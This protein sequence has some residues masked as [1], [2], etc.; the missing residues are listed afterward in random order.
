[1]GIIVALDIGVASVGWA[2]LDMDKE[3]ILE[4]GSNIFP[5]A[6]A[7]NNQKR[8]SMRQARRIKRRERIRIS[9][10]NK[11]WEKCIFRVPNKW[12]NNLVELRVHALY[13]EVSISELYMILQNALKHRGI[14]YLD[15]AL[16]DDANQGSGYEAMIRMNQKAMETKF[17]CE[18]QMERL[19]KYGQY[20]GDWKIIDSE[21]GE[22]IDFGN[23]FTTSAYKKEL[24]KIFETQ[25]KYHPELTDEFIDKYLKIFERKRK[26]YEGPGN[27]KSRTDYGKY[28]TRKNENGEYITEDNIF[29][30]LIGKCSVYPEELRAAGASYTSQEFNVLN[31]LNNL[32]INGRKLECEEKH[33]IVETIKTSK[34]VTMRKIIENVMGEKIEQLSGARIDKSDK[35]IF[36]KFETYNKM[37]KTLNEIGV[38][39]TTWSREQLDEIGYILTINTEKESIIEAFKNSELL[40]S[41]SEEVKEC[42]ITFRKK[43]GSL[44]SKWQSF[45][46]KIMKQL[47]PEMYEQP[48]EQMTLLHEMKLVK[49]HKE[50][51]KDCKYIPVDIL[52]EELY[53]PVVAKSVRISLK[54][55]NALLKKYENMEKIIIEMPRERNSD[56]EKKAIT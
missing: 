15:D 44:F 11:L 14:S 25:K 46:L 28:T 7:A 21:T 47:I 41:L 13:E 20:R 37:R 3:E 43:N 34:T 6:N 51:F 10:F 5:E 12:N 52:T 26:Y 31:D 24:E 22:E 17:P 39:I 16:S 4:A 54:I 27:E 19:N 2:V 50:L 29:E 18:I 9:D 33:K 45:S 42:L 36:H 49:N 35:E 56:E 53:N 38:D 55:I 23:V 30:K 40:N 1:M 8:R 32:T 48:K